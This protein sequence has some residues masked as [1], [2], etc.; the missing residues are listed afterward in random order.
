MK[1]YLF[2]YTTNPNAKPPRRKMWSK[3][4]MHIN[5]KIL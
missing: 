5:D 4:N 3:I 2:Q 1:D